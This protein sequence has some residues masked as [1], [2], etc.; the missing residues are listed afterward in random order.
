[1][2]PADQLQ[3]FMDFG[4]IMDKIK[5]K[6]LECYARHGV[7]IEENRLGQKFVVSA[8]LCMDTRKAG[9]NDDLGCSVDY[10]RVCHMINEFMRENTFKLIE[11]VAEKL[12]E[13]LL[14]NLPL[15]KQ[16]T[17]EIKK[18]WAPIGLPLESASVEITR[19]RHRAYIA[20]GSNMGDSRG[21]IEEAV[22][23]LEEVPQN[24]V[25]R[26]SELIVTK[27]YG[28]VEQ[29]DFLNGCLELDT[30]LTPEELLDITQNTE[31]E[32][33]RKRLIHWGPRT[34]DLDIIFYDDEIIKTERLTVPHPDMQNRTFV[35]KPMC[36]IAPYFVHPVYK[37]TMLKMLEEVSDGLA[38]NQEA[39]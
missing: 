25:V 4:G 14:I 3:G 16:V 29:D 27:P 9:I 19:S 13:L 2:M 32:A 18:P 15:V 11:T 26:Q 12:A 31:A 28:F 24:H 38:G 17:I 30:L 37:K 5:I 33:G 7:Y 34:L 10:G 21:I 39:D 1:M 6:N 8:E 36:E 35:L 20:L 23:K 22:K